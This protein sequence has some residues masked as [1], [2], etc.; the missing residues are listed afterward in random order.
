MHTWGPTPAEQVPLRWL[1]MQMD[2]FL[3]VLYIYIYT[4]PRIKLIN[5][6]FLVLYL[7][8]TKYTVILFRFCQF[9]VVKF[10]LHN[11][12]AA[13]W[14]STKEEL[15]GIKKNEFACT[16]DISFE[17]SNLTMLKLELF[18]YVARGT[19]NM[20][21]KIHLVLMLN[22]TNSWVLNLNNYQPFV[23]MCWLLKSLIKQHKD[24][25]QKTRL[26]EQSCSGAGLPCV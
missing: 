21:V 19:I 26:T 24:R 14:L 5:V 17:S 1:G 3:Q 6:L 13:V 10:L 18:Q 7:F 12:F 16:N 22:L 8:R 2:R 4:L 11:T 25:I 15:K 9:C 23:L 20:L